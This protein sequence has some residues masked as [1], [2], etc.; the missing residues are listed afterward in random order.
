LEGERQKLENGLKRVNFI[1]KI[2]IS[3]LGEIVALV[4]LA[5]LIFGSWIA[6]DQY[7]YSLL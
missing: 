6:I 5:A 7:I 2:I 3:T 4:T 1:M